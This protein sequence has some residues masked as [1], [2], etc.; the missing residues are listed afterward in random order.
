M[1]DARGR[2]V[3][4]RAALLPG[5]TQLDDTIARMRAARHGRRLWRCM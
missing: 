1:N 4:C 5:G 2:P 3:A